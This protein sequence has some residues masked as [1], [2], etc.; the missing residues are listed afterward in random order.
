MNSKSC[1]PPRRSIRPAPTLSCAQRPG[2]VGILQPRNR[3]AQPKDTK[4]SKNSKI[5]SPGLAFVF[6]PKR[7]E[8][9]HYHKDGDTEMYTHTAMS[10]R[11][12]LKSAPGV[13]ASIRDFMSLY[14]ENNSGGVS[15]DAYVSMQMKVCQ[16]LRP[17]M[18]T[19]EVRK[20]I[21]EDWDRDTKG[22]GEMSREGL[23]DS[24]FELCD[25]WC[26]SLEEAEYRSFFSQLR[27]RLLYEGHQNDSA[28]DILTN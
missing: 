20:V 2:A 22:T 19:G 24:L 12:A 14:T 1:R 25:V 4:T 28:Y 18:E 7:D 13:V 16:L 27:F 15:K 11:K 21:E 26:P 9:K 17:G 8:H 5:T 3:S 10:Q 23:F 6:N